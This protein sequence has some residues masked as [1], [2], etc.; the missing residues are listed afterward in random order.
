MTGCNPQRDCAVGSFEHSIAFLRKDAPGKS[1]YR[2][3]VLDQQNRSGEG[4]TFVGD[5]S[6]FFASL[7]LK[8]RLDGSGVEWLE[9]RRSQQLAGKY[10]SPACRALNL[11]ELL[12][13]FRAVADRFE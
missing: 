4:G 2:G 5:S 13:A 3:F 9:S 11:V 6:G 8:A 12:G 1:A 7:L 10:R